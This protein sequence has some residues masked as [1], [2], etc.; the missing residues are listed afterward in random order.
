[1]LPKKLYKKVVTTCRGC[2]CLT[3]ERPHSQSK[4]RS[5][6]NN[7]EPDKTTDVTYFYDQFLIHPHCMLETIEE[8]DSDAIIKIKFTN[9]GKA[10]LR[11]GK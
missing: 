6:C 11:G 9:S 1:M 8:D 10:I 3:Y 7:V 5:F 4:G 2:P